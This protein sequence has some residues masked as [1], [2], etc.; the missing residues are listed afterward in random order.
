MSIFP[1]RQSFAGSSTPAD[2][3]LEGS[4]HMTGEGWLSLTQARTFQ[5]G[6]ALFDV[7]FPS[8]SGISVQFDLA[9]YGGS[10]PPA[11]GMSFFLIDGSA[12]TEPGGPGGA[13]GYA[14]YHKGQGDA[15]PGVTKGY[16]GIGIDQYG[17]FSNPQQAGNG[18]PG[19]QP[20][21]AVLRGS[22]NGYDGYQYLSGA[23]LPTLSLTRESPTRVLLSII[24]NKVTVAVRQG[25]NWQPLIENYDLSTAGGQA[26]LPETLKLGL[27]AATGANTNDYEIRDLEVTLPADMPLHMTGP[28]TLQAGSP[29][30][31]TIKVR[32]NGPNA[33]PDAKVHGKIP[34]EVTG[35]SLGELVL[36]GG[37]TAGQGSVD[38]GTYTQLLTLPVGSSAIIPLNGTV[39][40]G[41]SGD[42]TCDGTITSDIVANTSSHSS[43]S[44]TTT[45]TAPPAQAD[46]P[47]IMSGPANADAGTPITYRMTVVNNG[48]SAVP[49]AQLTGATQQL[50]DVVLDASRVSGGVVAEQGTATGG[51]FTQPFSAFPQGGKAVVLLTGTINRDFTGGITAT[52]ET[53]TGKVTNTS[54]DKKGSVSTQVGPAQVDTKYTK[55]G[56]NQQSWP[57]DWQGYVWTYNFTLQATQNRICEW[58][59]Q[60]DVTTAG[61]IF[62]KGGNPDHWYTVTDDGS[63]G[64]IAIQSPRTGHCIEPDSQLTVTVWVFNPE[65]TD[66]VIT[67][68]RCYAT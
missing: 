14:C 5:A 23:A 51:T 54:P 13:L 38:D 62:N 39:R 45:V 40:E 49:E 50:T 53:D 42:I 31:Y 41:T 21:F 4:A 65:R 11:D 44:V 52:S 46:V 15:A 66:G 60:F 24:S 25:E 67:N 37:A 10:N 58:T 35:A 26:P 47:L 36:T 6:T 59:L 34:S 68:V 32:N 19:Q 61:S 16:V 55:S 12:Q 64:T 18:G 7:A 56:P 33:A 22:G 30:G 3:R 63:N 8:D 57:P 9:A 20:D 17:S 27:S 43:D 29:I 2:W 28:Q 1:Y 48:P